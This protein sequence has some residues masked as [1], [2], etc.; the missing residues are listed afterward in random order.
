MIFN[1]TKKIKNKSIAQIINIG[2]ILI[3]F[4]LF[5]IFYEQNSNMFGEYSLEKIEKTSA[6]TRNYILYVS[7]I[8]SGS[9]YNLGPIEPGL[10][11]MISKFPKAVNV[12]L[13][14]PYLWESK[15]IIVF[16]NALESLAILLVTIKVLLLIGLRKIVKS[17]RENY[18][19]QFTIIFSLIFSFFVGI[20]S[21][22][23]GALSRY[24]IPCI[25]FYLL[26]LVL[27]YY[28]HAKPGN[29]LFKSLNL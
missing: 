15:K 26:T 21:Y 11:G 25:P 3:T 29:R 10:S 19:I 7:E 8:E 5:F 23:F 27:I 4:C 22:N 9:S 16:L 13:F 28:E 20:S 18:T 2:A 14:R 17:I 6:K 12:T 24:K 1:N